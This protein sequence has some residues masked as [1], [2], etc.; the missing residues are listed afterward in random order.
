MVIYSVK[1][2]KAYSKK[3]LGFGWN[4]PVFAV[5][6]F[7]IELIA[8]VLLVKN[9]AGFDFPLYGSAT[10][11]LPQAMLQNASGSVAVMAVF[12]WPFY[13]AIVVAGLCVAAR[14]YHKKVELPMI[15]QSK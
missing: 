4:K 11:Q 14:L 9:F 6:I 13:F 3:L 8:L 15:P 10:V 5:A 7:V 1:P 12:E 2:D